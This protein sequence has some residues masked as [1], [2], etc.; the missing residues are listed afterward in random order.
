MKLTIDTEE[1]TLCVITPSVSAGAVSAGAAV[2]HDAPPGTYP[3]YSAEAFEILSSQWLPLSW[4]REHWMSFSWMG[5]QLLQLPHDVLRLAELVW[6]LRPVVIIETGVYEGGSTLLFASLCRLAGAGRVISVDLLLRPGVR[7]AVEERG[8]GLVTLIE[9]DSASA[10][11]AAQV[12]RLIRDEERVFVFLD[13]A[14]TAEHVAAELELYAP[15]V[16]PGSYLVVA[17]TNLPELRDT[18]NGIIQWAYDHP[19]AAV[20]SFLS[21]HPEFE[22]AHPKPL[23]AAEQDCA[24]LS[25]FAG[26]WLTRRA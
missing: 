16:T 19:M 26:S 6:V 10:E 14:H 24:Y 2:E 17:D 22:R 1:K 7:E 18:P 8:G 12:R 20:D 11:T 15:L 3:L 23:F 13:S 9:G 5:R 25:Y 21:R 4:N